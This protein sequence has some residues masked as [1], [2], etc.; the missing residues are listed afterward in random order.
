QCCDETDRPCHGF[1]LRP[2]RDRRFSYARGR[3]GEAGGFWKQ[4]KDS[5]SFGP[6]GEKSFV[7]ERTLG[8]QR[9]DFK[10]SEEDEAFRRD[11]RN[12]L[13]KNMPRDWHDEGEL[14]D[15]DTKEEF[16]RRRGWH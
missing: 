12:W 3:R 13:E 2:L 7:N 16:E 9:M 6:C 8:A 14:H 10:F 15:P 4:S 5:P 11:F 1:G